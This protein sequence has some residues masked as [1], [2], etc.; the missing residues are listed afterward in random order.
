MFFLI[1]GVRAR[2]RAVSSPVRRIESCPACGGRRVF[3]EVRLVP[4]FELFFI[5]LLP[6]GR[7]TR[8]LRCSNCGFDVPNAI[9]SGSW[10]EV[11]SPPVKA[12]AEPRDWGFGS[13]RRAPRAF[14]EQQIY[15]VHCGRQFVVRASD[16]LQHVRCPACE[17][18][19]EIGL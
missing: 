2:K 4:Y 15:C 8:A 10:S 18:D 17:R 11:E 6:V 9:W 14:T 13:G 12:E 1:A 5:P 7:G 19:F 3:E 16:G